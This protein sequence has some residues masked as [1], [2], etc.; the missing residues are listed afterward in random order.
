MPVAVLLGSA[1]VFAPQTF[2]DSAFADPG[3]W[4]PDPDQALG[5]A[6][7]SSPIVTSVDQADRLGDISNWT[8]PVGGVASPDS[9]SGT[10]AFT[11]G[12]T[13]AN[14]G[15]VDAYVVWPTHATTGTYEVDVWIPHHGPLNGQS[16]RDAEHAQ[17]SVLDAGGVWR[18]AATIDQ[19]QF[20][21]EWVSI[22]T[23]QLGP[24]SAVRLGDDVGAT[25]YASEW[26]IFDAVRI[27]KVT[28]LQ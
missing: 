22:G 18:T 25:T 26:V 14:W 5:L 12:G 9:G 6:P 20:S 21:N 2:A 11:Q 15:G 23:F 7:A 24:H 4:S 8:P 1:G 16:R 27:W 28:G 13:A 19:E 3:W 10:F 17:Y